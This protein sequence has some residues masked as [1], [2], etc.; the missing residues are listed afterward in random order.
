[1]KKVIVISIL[2]IGISFL[3][4]NNHIIDENQAIK[5]ATEGLNQDFVIVNKSLIKETEKL[6]SLIKK[7]YHIENPEQYKAIWFVS[8]EINDG[9]ELSSIYIDAHSGEILSSWLINDENGDVIDK[10]FLGK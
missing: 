10:N 5:I 8:Y 7:Y 3:L 9:K 4:I 2:L 1:M 6:N